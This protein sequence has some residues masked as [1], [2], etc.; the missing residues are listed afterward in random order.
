[1][2][3]PSGAII[4]PRRR[5]ATGWCLTPP[6]PPRLDTRPPGVYKPTV[7]RKLKIAAA[8]LFAAAASAALVFYLALRPGR[9]PA[10]ADALPGTLAA[11]ARFTSPAETFDAVATWK[12]LGRLAGG[13]VFGALGVGLEAE[14]D[15]GPLRL[16]PDVL[17]LAP[18]VLGRECA[19]G[20]RAADDGELRWL[21]LSKIGFGFTA[22]EWALR[23]LGPEGAVSIEPLGGG[24]GGGGG[25]GRSVRRLDLG[26]AAQAYYLLE[27]DLFVAS[28]SKALVADALAAA[29]PGS[30]AGRF[31]LPLPSPGPS[32]AEGGG[33]GHR[34]SAA[35]VSLRRALRAATGATGAPEDAL[36][37][38]FTFLGL[39]WPAGPLAVTVSDAGEGRLALQ[40]VVGF[41]PALIP[42]RA[43]GFVT[44]SPSEWTGLDAV[45][46]DALFHWSWRAT[47][48]WH[49]GNLFAQLASEAGESIGHGNSPAIY[50]ISR[51]VFDRVGPHLTGDFAAFAT[52]QKSRDPDGGYPAVTWLFGTGDADAVRREVLA[53]SLVWA[54]GVRQVRD[55]GGG[56]GGG[57]GRTLEF[58]Y[59]E[60]R[61]YRGA[62]IY[63]LRGSFVHRDHGFEPCFSA[64][65][66]LL[67]CST[68]FSGL[69]R[70]MD[71][72][73]G[74]A[75]RL[76]I[77][78]QP[79]PGGP[80]GADA[81]SAA[82]SF[83]LYAVRPESMKQASNLYDYQ[84]E[85]YRARQM[86]PE[87]ALTDT[88]DY[89]ARYAVFEELAR[90]VDRA[91]LTGRYGPMGELRVWAEITPTRSAPAPPRATS[92]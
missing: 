79:G 24:G 51:I 58:P 33:G 11:A 81:A 29:A 86:T 69:K 90:L 44:R 67:I 62:K 56:G 2:V 35:V 10:V 87:Q 38:I 23:H 47:D 21:F 83:A 41:D 45:P 17:E 22:R 64:T 26:E 82:R 3:A 72:L 32:D 53:G 84:V 60:S 52:P 91:A 65:G 20:L 39:P 34:A 46:S 28:D 80:G 27:G 42:D 1:M 9:G 31:E 25:G 70:S 63:L 7:R 57:G 4:S 75:P 19:V 30:G 54:T 76:V 8:V 92:R 13:R 89:R 37:N 73:A 68:S 49:L 61:V 85:M 74:E 12:P 15:D 6:R 16:P 50:E 48:G 71:A 14:G 36:T 18:V 59:L 5:S 88:T 66:K 55:D 78:R 77:S 43:R 40:A